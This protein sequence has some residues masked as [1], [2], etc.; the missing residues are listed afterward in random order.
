[1]KTLEG[2]GIRH[3]HL[4]RKI[5]LQLNNKHT[6]NKQ[7][8]KKNWGICYFRDKELQK[9]LIHAKEHRF[10]FIRNAGHTIRKY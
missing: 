5:T 10:M 9:A 7:T 4:G 3:C 2:K 8:R 1:M 6:R